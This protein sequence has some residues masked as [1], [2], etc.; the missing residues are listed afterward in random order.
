[1]WGSFGARF[2]AVG[3]VVSARVAGGGGSPGRSIAETGSG[4]GD[5]WRSLKRGGTS[6]R[7]SGCRSAANLFSSHRPTG[8]VCHLRVKNNVQLHP[9]GARLA[10]EILA[11]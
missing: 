7:F 11:G 4:W 1:M 10:A 3:W 8:V 9:T 6:R 2:L 5:N